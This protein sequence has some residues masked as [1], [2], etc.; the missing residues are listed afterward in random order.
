MQEMDQNGEVEGPLDADPVAAQ[1]L[2]DLLQR[3]GPL[4]GG[5]VLYHNVSSG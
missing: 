5:K 2:Q 3:H 1:L 4:V